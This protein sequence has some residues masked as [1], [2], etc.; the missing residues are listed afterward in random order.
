[1]DASWDP[2]RSTRKPLIINRLRDFLAKTADLL[3]SQFGAANFW[4]KQF[5]QGFHSGIG[6]PN[7]RKPFK[8]DPFSGQNPWH[9]DR[10][11]GVTMLQTGRKSLKWPAALATFARAGKRGLSRTLK[12]R[13]Q[14]SLQCETARES[15][16]RWDKPRAQAKQEAN[17]SKT[18]CTTG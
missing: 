12:R 9:L 3:V 1:V 8:K 6:L 15:A 2:G 11:G 16:K 18:R 13:A 7:P 4:R 17:R 5:P 10:R 14:R